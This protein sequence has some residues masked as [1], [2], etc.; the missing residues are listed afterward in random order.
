M[1]ARI[2]RRAVLQGALVLAFSLAGPP[3]LG[4]QT[5]P[6]KLPGDLERNPQLDA[7]L[8]IGA[9]GGV[10]LKTGKVELGQGVLTAF[11][12][13]CAD[14][15]DIELSRLVIVSGDTRHS[16]RQGATAGS[17]SMPEGGTAVRAAAA[18]ARAL[19]LAMAGERLGV[20]VTRL[21]VQDGTVTDSTGGKSITYWRLMG[22]RTWNRKATGTVAPKPASARRYIGR[23]IARVDLPGKLTGEPSFVQDLRPDRLAHGRVVRAL[24]RARRSSRPTWP[25]C[26]TCRECSG[27]CAMG[28]S[29]ASSRRRNGRPTRRRRASRRAP[30]GGNTPVSRRTPTPGCWDRRPRTRSSIRPS[31]RRV[32]HRRGPWRRATAARM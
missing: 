17:M 27:W 28:T 10:T 14:E 30:G 22:G 16:P 7:R 24:P 31:A 18:E 20:P 1:S 29:W 6:G 13:L 4:A 21:T 8:R 9:D 15:L 32:P 2:E 11:A 3:G 23:P 19:L 25:P 12:Q 26:G 5:A